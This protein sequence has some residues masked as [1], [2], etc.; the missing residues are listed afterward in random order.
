MELDSRD[1]A[2][3]FMGSKDGVLTDHIDKLASKYGFT[4]DYSGRQHGSCS[5][6]HYE[7]QVRNANVFGLVVKEH[8]EDSIS[9]CSVARCLQDLKR[10]MKKLGLWYIGIQAF[11]DPK[12][13][14]VMRKIWTVIINS[15]FIDKFEVYFCWPGNTKE[16][17]WEEAK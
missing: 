15:L 9:F 14:L 1:C 4:S 16:M 17:C 13:D 3:L 12:Y 2:L 11:D 7:N 10:V 8:H 5:L 6:Y